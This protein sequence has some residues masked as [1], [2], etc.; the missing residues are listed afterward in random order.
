MDVAG[1]V[2]SIITFIDFSW[3]IVQGTYSVYESASGATEDNV[4]INHVL[5]D[6]QKAT[7]KIS[8]TMTGK[9]E[10]EKDLLKLAYQCHGLSSK[11][12]VTLQT[13][14]TDKRSGLQSFNIML[15]SL[16]KKKEVQE[17]RSQLGEYRQQIILRLS[18]IS[19]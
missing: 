1:L 12:A 15:R 6:L 5:Q 16:I 18:S 3:T 9:D 7:E 8:T 19:L 14:R 10:D 4:Q 2:S 13:L 17:I 11:L